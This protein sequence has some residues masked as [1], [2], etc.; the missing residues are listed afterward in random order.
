MMN[1]IY[2][3]FFLCGFSVLS[4][5]G[6]HDHGQAPASPTSVERIRTFSASK[7]SDMFQ[8]KLQK[9]LYRL[10]EQDVLDCTFIY[11]E[12]REY[13][14]KIAQEN[15]NV[16]SSVIDLRRHGYPCVLMC[17][18]YLC[19]FPCCGEY[20]GSLVEKELARKKYRATIISVLSVLEGSEIGK[21]V[22]AEK[23]KRA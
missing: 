8:E 3:V 16:Q 9:E 2:R 11:D 4:L 6:C 13:V 15:F 20:Q 7:S 17:C 19:Q 5:L 21:P 12:R 22:V 23:I 1:Y 10:D 18:E 14:E